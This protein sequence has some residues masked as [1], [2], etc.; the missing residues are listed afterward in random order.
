VV[1][2]RRG[3]SGHAKLAFD[4]WVKKYGK[5]LREIELLK[6]REKVI[7]DQR[8]RLDG[9][10][11]KS[12]Q[13]QLDKLKKKQDGVTKETETHLATEAKLL[14]LA[15]VPPREAEAKLVGEPR[16]GGRGGR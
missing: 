3:S 11:S 6:G 9:K 1:L 4:A 7:T 13:G 2:L 14:E 8:G 16:R 12:N 5:F 10:S 15:K